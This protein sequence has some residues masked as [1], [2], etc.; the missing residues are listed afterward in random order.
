MRSRHW[1][2][3]ILAA[4]SAL[5]LHAQPATA[6]GADPQTPIDRADPAVIGEELREDGERQGK[7]FDADPGVAAEDNAPRSGYAGPVT[8]GAIRIDGASDLPP[9]AFAPTVG[10]YAGREISV[11]ELRELARDVANVARQAGYGLATAFVPPQQLANG[12]L[13]VRLDLGAIDA[14]EVEGDAATVVKRILAPV[15]NG[16]PVRTIDLER[17]LLLAGDVAGVRMGKA[18]LKQEGGRSILVVKATRDERLARLWMDNWGSDTVGPVRARLSYDVNGLLAD[19]DR[20][21]VGGL[22]TPLDLGEF[23]L[24]SVSYDEG[25]G[26][27]GTVAGID[28]YYARS[29]PGGVLKDRDIAGTS[30]AVEATLSHPFLR[31]RAAS[32]WGNFALGVRGVEQTVRGELV[33]TDQITTITA[34]LFGVT[35]DAEARLRARLSLTQGLPMFGAT[36][37]G[38]PLRSRRD[39]DGVFTKL[40]GWVEYLRELGGNFSAQAQAEGQLASGPLLSSDE[41]GLGGRTYLRG[42]DYREH[43]GDK[44]VAG[45]LELRYDLGDAVKWKR[46]VQLYA[47]GDAGTV[48]NYEGG[49]GGGTLASAGGG[50]RVRVIRNMEANLELAIP[51]E[52]GSRTS[53]S[54]KPRLSFSIY[55]RF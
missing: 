11:K 12:V 9:A 31:T 35:G 20:L 28:A 14:V 19:D 6:A 39:A 16:A 30:W 32:V 40:E 29:N 5:L 46:K 13:H 49:F 48:R 45:S 4:L 7:T 53:E 2:K 1:A 23:T 10:R 27:S 17:Q 50:I 36:R 42:Y 25:V 26:T 33:R 44:G 8:V 21:S 38:D 18:R 34:G 22:I 3:A 43:S 55:G 37:D 51:L 54:A 24:A 41:M 47:Y 15:A 52:T